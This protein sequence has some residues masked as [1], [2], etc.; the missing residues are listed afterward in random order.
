MAL[1]NTEQLLIEAVQSM[2]DGRT[3]LGLPAKPE[4]WGGD[5]D[6]RLRGLEYLHGQIDEMFAH[7]AAELTHH[8]GACAAFSKVHSHKY[9]D[10][11]IFA[12]AMD[13]EMVSQGIPVAE[14]KQAIG[15]IPAIIKE[16]KEEAE[17]WSERDFGFH[18]DLDDIIKASQP[19]QFS[20]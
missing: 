7:K 9:L 10:D 13:S 8:T 14:R 2:L 19:E 3:K 20:L 17:N 1:D 18:P 4:S 16:L 11:P 6:P 15:F 5:N 12:K